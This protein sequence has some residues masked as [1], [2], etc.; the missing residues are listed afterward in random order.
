MRKNQLN[1]KCNH[2]RSSFLAL[3]GTDVP[4]RERG[5]AVTLRRTLGAVLIGAAL[6]AQAALPAAAGGIEPDHAHTFA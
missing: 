2:V 6:M 5:P 1:K 3:A 4:Q